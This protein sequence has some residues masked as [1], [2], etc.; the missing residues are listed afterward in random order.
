MLLRRHILAYS[1]N[2]FGASLFSYADDSSQFEG[3]N[4]IYGRSILHNTSVGLLTYITHARVINCKM[5]RFCSVGHQAIVGGFGRHPTHWVSTHPVFYS[6]QNQSGIS[7]ADENYFDELQPVLIGND[8]WIGARAM[9]L[10]GVKIGD[11]AIIAA[12]A[13]VVKDVEPYAIVGGVPAKKIRSRF[14]DVLV[15]KL[16]EIKWWDWPIE[17][18]KEAAHLFRSD[19]VTAIE[20]LIKQGRYG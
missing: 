10:D 9:V 20:E 7:F 13:V 1:V 19:D 16:L 12:G 11:G 8:V 15:A 4:R 3:Y 5:G 6:T 17:K 14:N 2:G 18:L